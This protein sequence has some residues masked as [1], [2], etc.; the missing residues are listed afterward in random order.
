MGWIFSTY[1]NLVSMSLK[2]TLFTLPFLVLVTFV[3]AQP[4]APCTNGTQN[5]CKCNTS[6]VLCSIEELDGYSYSMTWYLH[7]TDGPHGNP[8]CMCPGQCNTTSHNPTWFR[9]P[10]WCENLDLE[11]CWSGCTQNP[12][13]CNSRGIQSAVY[14]ECFGCPPPE[15][16]GPSWNA[17]QNPAPY[18][19]AVGCDVDG[20]GP[21]SGCAT[22]NMTGL[23]LGK[24]YYFLVDG[25]CGSACNVDISVLSPCGVPEIEDF[26]EIDGP[27][28]VCAGG[29]E[30]EYYH[31]RPNGSTK[32]F[33][34]L[35]G[36]LVQAGQTG[37]GRWWR[38]TWTTPGEYEL[39]F[40]ASQEPCIPVTDDPDPSCI[41]I[42]V[43]DI[44][45]EDVEAFVCPGE[46]FTYNNQN[47]GP[48]QY[49]FP[50][51]TEQGCDSTVTLTVIAN[52]IPEEDL[53]V[54]EL[55]EGECYEV[56]GVDY[57][58]T[59]QFEVTLQ[60]EV[61][62]FCDSIVIFEIV[63]YQPDAGTITLDSPICPE[64]TSSISVS[65]HNAGPDFEQYIVVVN[66][67]GAIVAVFNGSTGSFTFDDCAEF[68]VYSI[69]FHP[70]GGTDPPAV[71][72]PIADY[73]CSSGCCDITSVPLIFQ[74][75]QA[76]TFV[77]PPPSVTLTCLLALD[78]MPILTWNDNCLGTGTVAG[79]QTGEAN[80]CEGGTITRTWT[81]EDICGNSAEHVQ[82][83]T[84]D[85]YPEF[86]FVNPPDDITIVCDS[87]PTG[88]PP[89]VVTNG[90]QGVCLKTDTIPGVLTGSA[91]LCGGE[92]T[93]TWT[94]VDTCNRTI[95]HTQIITAAPTPLPEWI[96]PP[97][98]QNIPCANIPTSGP[99]LV[100]SNGLTGDCGILDTIAP[101]LTG[102][103]DL[104]GG[105]ITLTWEF[106]DPC[107]TTFEHVQVL[108]VDPV[109]QA[110]FVNAPGNITVTCANIPTS[111]PNLDYTNGLSGA[112]GIS[113]TAT[114][115]TTGSA[116]L[117]GG[118]I[119]NTWTFTDVCGRTTT[120]TQ[121]IT[122]TPVPQATFT[123]PPG[124]ITITCADIP[125]THPNLDYTNGLS[126]ACLI[127]GTTTPVVTGSA[128][129]CGGT[130][131]RTWSFTDVCGRQTQHVQTITVTPVPV[132]AFVNP[133]ASITVDCAN[134]PTSA[135]PLAFTNGLSGSCGISGTV[136]AV[137][138]GSANLCGGTITFT[139]TFTDAC[140]RTIQHVQNVTVTPVPVATFTNPPQSITIQCADIPT[141]APPLSYTNGLS[142]AC[143]I[144]GSVPAV[145]TGSANLCG[146][147]ITNTWTF[148]DACGRTITHTQVITVQP[149]P[150]AAF[151]NPPQS[152]TVDCYNIPTSAPP[153]EYTNGLTGSCLISGTATPT[154]SGSAN[155]CGG[156]ITFTWTFTDVCGR[157]ITHTQNVTVTP[158][159]PAAF[160]NPPPN[161]NVTCENIPTSAPPLTYT[162]G[163]TGACAISGSVPAVQTGSAGLCG[164]VIQ[165]TWTFTDQCNRTIQ[166]V[167]T[168]I[169][170]PAPV[171]SFINPPPNQ[172][173]TCDQIPSGAPTLSY[174]NGLS[175]NC[176]I[177]GSVP[178]TQTGG[179]DLCGG[180]INYTWSFTDQC[181][182][183]IQHVQSITVTPVPE[184]N[185]QNPP[186]D[187]VTDCNN[188]PASPPPLTFTNG[189][190]GNC[191]I[192]A[193]V[194]PQQIGNPSVCGGTY[195][196][197]WTFTDPCGRTKTHLQ[198]ITI[199]PTPQASFTNP[200]ADITVA[201]TQ[202]NENP[203]NLAYTNN[204]TGQCAIQGAV[205]AQQT[206]S[207]GP[208]G[209][210]LFNTWT[211][212]DQCN[213]TITHVQTVTVQ[214]APPAAFENLP[215]D[216]TV[217]CDN[218]PGPDEFVT[219]TNGL[220]GNCVIQGAIQPFQ[221]GQYDACGGVIS[222]L[223]TFQDDC[224]RQISHTQNVTILPAPPPEFVGP[225]D[226]ATVSCSEAE[227]LEAAPLISYSNYQFG[228]CENSGSVFGVQNATYNE[229]GGTVQY[230]WTLDACGNPVNYTQTITV[231][232]GADPILENAPP[233]LTLE[234]GQPFPPTPELYYFNNEFGL[235]EISGFISP[236]IVEVNNVQ[237]NTWNFIHPCTGSTI[238]RTQTIVGK[239]VPGMQVT[240]DTVRICLGGSFDL[241]SLQI[242]DLNNAFPNITFHSGTPATPANQI[243]NLNVS[244]L[245]GTTYYILGT[246]Q[247][248]C[249]AEVT[250]RL[251][252]DTPVTAG[253]DG[254]G[255]LCH[256][257][258]GINL[259]DYIVGN[260]STPGAWTDPFN[261]G[262]DI[263]PPTNVS[264]VGANPGTY[265]FHY[266]VQNNGACPGDTAVVTLELVPEVD[267]IPDSLV[268]DVS[269]DFYSVYFTLVGF[270]P[271]VSIGNLTNLGNG[272]WLVTPIPVDSSLQI[273]GVHPASGCSE[274]VVIDPPNCNCP[275]VPP[276]T[277]LG[278]KSICAGQPTPTLEVTVGADDIANWYS[279]PNGGTLLAG[280]TTSYTPPV[281]TPGTYIYYV[282]AVNAMFP[283]CKSFVRTP[284]TLSI[285]AAPTVNNGVLKSCDANNDGLATFTLSQ[286][287]P[288]INGNPNNT[289]VYY[290]SLQDAQN[291][292][293][294]LPNSFTNTVP[295]QQTVYAVVTNPSGCFSQAE[296]TLIVFP[297]IQLT[298]TVTNETCLGDADGTLTI[299]STGG[300]GQVLYSLTN[301]NF[302]SQTNY[303]GLAAGA[304]TVFAR[305]TFNCA[306][307]QP[308]SVLPGLDIDIDA[309][310]V[311]CNNNGTA[312]DATDDF[313]TITFTVNNNQANTGTFTVT[314]PGVS[315][316]P[317]TYGQ[318][319]SFTL[320][321]NGQSLLFTISDTQKG[322][323]ITQQAGP[324]NPCSTDCLLTIT[325]MNKVCNDAGTN[326]DPVDDFYTFTVNAT[327]I[328]PGAS[329]SFNVF[330]GGVLV[331][332]FPY[333]TGGSFTLPADGSN[334]VVLFVDANDDQC[335]ASQTAGILDP[336]SNTCVIVATITNIDCD[337]NNTG[338][339][340]LDDEFTFD[341]TVTGL[342][343][344]GSW[345]V[346]GN[347]GQTY[348]YGAAHPFGPYLIA[349]GPFTLTLVDQNDPGCTVTINVN[350]PPPC[351]EP[352]DLEISNLVIGNCNNNNTGPITEDDFF[353]VL[354]SVTATSG[355][356][357]QFI[358]RLDTL[359][360]GPFNYGGLAN[361]TGLPAN[362]QNLV[363][364]ITD[365]NNT[366]C[367]ATVTVSRDPCSECNQ[368]ASA[369]P[370]FVFD[371]FIQSAILQGSASPTL[372]ASYLWTGPNNFTSTIPTPLVSFP[373]VY[374][375]TVTYP[376][377]CTVVDSLQITI[378]PTVPFADAG[379]DRVLTC[380]VDSV[381][382]DGSG[383]SSGPDE[384]YIWTDINN[385]TVGTAKSIWVKIPGT[386]FLQ[387]IDLAKN[388][389][390]PVSQVIVTENRNFPQAPIYADPAELINCVIENVLL[391]T[392]AQANV[393]FTWEQNGNV[394]PG[395]QVI[396]N[397]PGLV[398]LTAVDTTNGCSTSKQLFIEDQTEYPI[399]NVKDLGSLNCRDTE[400]VI[401][402][403]QSQDGATIIFSWYDGNGNL[404][405]EGPLR[406]LTVTATGTY[407]LTVADTANG[408]SN[409]DTIEVF[410]DYDFPIVD[411]GETVFLPCD[412]FETGLSG[413]FG[414]AGTT[415][416]FLWTAGSGGVVLA[417]SLTLTPRVEGSAWYTLRILNTDNGCAAF[418]SVY[419]QANA[420]EPRPDLAIS[421]VTCKGENDGSIQVRGVVNGQPP[422]TISLNGQVSGS[423]SFT[424]LTPGTYL[425]EIVDANNC[426]YDTTI[427]LNEGTELTLT[428]SAN[429]ILVIEG[430]S[431]IVEA[432]VNVPPDQ[433][434][435]VLW[436]PGIYLSCD[437]CLITRIVPLNTQEYQVT[438]TDIN[439]CTA[440]D[441]LL[442]VVKKE[443][444]V[445]IPN[446]FSPD[447]N[448]INDRF[449]LYGDSKVKMIRLM[450]IYDR[451]GGM[452]FQANDIPPNDPQFGW[453]GRTR[454]I[455]V[456]LG[457]Y[458]YY[459]EVEFTDG[460]IE[461]FK[462]DVNV[463]TKN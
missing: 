275:P 357:T 278:D 296:L 373:G 341:I 237:T 328:N 52:P 171:A 389:A 431:A 153:L 204:Q 456:E 338:N 417:G 68:T 348:T 49:T 445:Y 32:L 45:P 452:M 222:F 4:P 23:V 374:I 142:G 376:D 197:L 315:Q 226:D 37:Q 339:D 3:H 436:T 426:T 320:P 443:T 356:V 99:P 318:S 384:I 458:V 94:Y 405:Q 292:V 303:T 236:D 148:T 210:T 293:N 198:N 350:P 119:T 174:T 291:Q 196:Y 90:V 144:V 363:L 149:V 13:Q 329:N 423:G 170:A 131:T 114:P 212:T 365:L 333:G 368:T 378:D 247:F 164:G 327:A 58:A 18:T 259:F 322:C 394:T 225:P 386:Y 59:G 152:I 457:V 413:S 89:L 393:V 66:A 387:V 399:V 134:I 128:D 130:I 199:T 300:T 167:Q 17:G 121:T 332:T 84:I 459:F 312:T 218:I 74:D 156:T 71:G 269:Q 295:F 276:P 92:L 316:G 309:F 154:Q 319:H 44:T 404:I 5:T 48:G 372:G 209:G 227:L 397:Q 336:C 108:T 157:T 1:C 239:P 26:V 83:I 383:S 194:T 147:T 439:G 422:Y 344:S 14:S 402:A 102:S 9:F 216:I 120:H 294:P 40:D 360:W 223:W 31:P 351:S 203:P 50:F 211:F 141:S 265:V 113:G 182:R 27:T 337:N 261:S 85:P 86:E 124:N 215:Q 208:C 109:P 193:S 138:T 268:C 60:Q 442:V 177:N 35:D 248:G 321:A 185:Y 428:L 425:L 401:D 15:C 238:T 444:K 424:P 220:S 54:I 76:P 168:V 455:P 308:F 440:R 260:Y 463:I 137:Q 217:S 70:H 36:V 46:Q 302:N 346:S 29:D 11:V 25:C 438:V 184:G 20:C 299:S 347:P 165:F 224:G 343:T 290:G 441:F 310:T 88:V 355:S 228:D 366:A 377:Q 354:F 250:F 245:V 288:Q 213:R 447:G 460:R 75:T 367:Q 382:L 232:P 258:S 179:A 251:E 64:D 206:G 418:D 283:N 284:V 395:L 369:G 403:T 263:F 73:D 434:G 256:G 172:T 97:A 432:I 323:P 301:Q 262:I 272:K 412:V 358:V 77:N 277:N 450:R 159:A 127:A 390:S 429:S 51:E 287:N 281:S 416:E 331:G 267:V 57:C 129:L 6:P 112:C 359:Q 235:C 111:A 55:C 180:V 408:C 178:A 175:G 133:P 427:V 100:I 135:P 166:H 122:V 371:C 420:D 169:V 274:T 115:V 361:I 257:A 41:T 98:S 388:C 145:T 62:P 313:Y 349:N 24:V 43:Y 200:P 345:Y 186:P 246:T 298:L 47:Y 400:V 146:G 8:A 189:L 409:R 252:V 392:D 61:E 396:I 21:T 143:G 406:T 433:I 451:W 231:L 307:S 381:L 340:S 117:C 253:G 150:V 123:N 379:P 306:V 430:D 93:A 201:C 202:V 96:N 249:Q 103:A 87:I 69:N 230:T 255:F 407:F 39:C 282:E 454:G 162:N 2:T 326:A 33:W 280:N 233:D 462:G 30:V 63:V 116:D 163:E 72:D 106:E 414:N 7:P 421:P 10:A 80:L 415:P 229:C 241:G 419:V 325:A 271:S 305:D 181:G 107:G 273:T 187:I 266:I 91:D 16:Y 118:T 453:D 342:N 324:F 240:P 191:G 28:Y 140:G 79:V 446:A 95:V 380:A 461:T 126:G 207:Y 81:V 317:F 244:P 65:G 314:A 242:V 110:T 352:C 221:S 53:G 161:Q 335:F 190:G 42:T 219:Y 304:Y 214:P 139:W 132:A 391:F 254:G 437:S 205:A 176:G 160:V 364:I 330:V 136:P 56:G 183:I 234:C 362:G 289:I 192:F 38:T 125:T 264:F 297:T 158:I 173:V 279:A 285:L 411:A 311:A 243:T 448:I 101:V 270:T 82:T 410:G 195:S 104:C 151:V 78:T 370:D 375:L 286:A 19:F 188:I 155:L 22:I 353:N 67:A 435:A 449:T 398:T 105:E 34:Y 385:N 12:G 334:P